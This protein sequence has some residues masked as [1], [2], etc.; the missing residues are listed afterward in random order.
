MCENLLCTIYELFVVREG[1]RVAFIEQYF[2][3]LSEQFQVADDDIKN[4]RDIYIRFFSTDS[5]QFLEKIY[6]DAM[7][8][9]NGLPY[10]KCNE[11]LAGLIFI[12]EIVARALWKFNCEITHVLADFTREFDRLDVSDECWRLYKIAQR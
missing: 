6:E 11:I 5:I 3:G 9:M 4:E 7:K 12:Q 10:E 2:S 1:R 8:E